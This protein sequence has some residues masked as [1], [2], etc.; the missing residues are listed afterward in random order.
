MNSFRFLIFFFCAI[1]VAACT[2]DKL[3]GEMSI[4]I[5]TWNWTETYAVS[6]YCDADSLWN[7]QLIDSAQT[8]KNFKLEF[9]EKGKVIFYNNDGVLW[10]DRVVF[11][12]KNVIENGS[13]A[14]HF[15]ILLNNK[16]DDKLDVW[17]G[18]DS[19]LLNDFPKDTDDHCSE[20]FNHFIR[21]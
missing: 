9:Q 8:N 4:L 2:K 13:Y 10:N 7:Y 5:G 14:Y 12:S 18:Q 15:V 17:V 6:N 1:A 11:E 20:M 16:T 3:E 19:L 21:Q